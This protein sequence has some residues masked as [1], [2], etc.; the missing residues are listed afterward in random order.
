VPRWWCGCKVCEEARSTG[1]N[2]RG[3]PA[4]LIAGEGER[5]LVDAPPELRLHLTRERV[6]SLDALL[7]THAHNDHVLGLGD[8]ADMARWTGKGVPIYAPAEVLPQVM[9]RFPYLGTG[10]YPALAPFRVLE[11]PLTL[12]GYRVSAHRVPHGYNGFAYG[13]RFE[14][15]GGAWAYVPDSLGITDLGPWRGLELLVLGTS[16]YREAAPREKR[17]VYDVGEAVELLAELKPERAVFT[18]LG[19][20]VD[21][22]KP[23]PAGT[24]YAFD[25]MR[26]TL[27]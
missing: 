14:G 27:P 16:F 6:R 17:S 2:A 12:A 1:K 21:R 24:V 25:G 10:N 19:H 13:L 3:R 9:A 4:V 26:V 11:P 8:V 7:V 20:G 15:A 5:V 23:A 18:H 22:R